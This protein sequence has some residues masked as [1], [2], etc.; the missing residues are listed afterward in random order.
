ML[1]LFLDHNVHALV[2]QLLR[3]RQVDVLT[4]FEAECHELADDRLLERAT[5]LGRVLFSHDD[6]LLRE[7]THRQRRGLPFTG[8]IYC[9]QDRLTL[10]Q[11]VDQL[12][13]VARGSADDEMKD[14]VLFLPV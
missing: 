5:E 8:V 9:H 12:E 1:R 13:L 4:A 3:E 11:L 6:D 7:G 10:A 2:S 14:R